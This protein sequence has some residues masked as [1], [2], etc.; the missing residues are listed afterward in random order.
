MFFRDRK[1]TFDLILT[2]K[3]KVFQNPF[4]TETGLSDFHKLILTFFQTLITLLKPKIVFYRNYKHFQESRFLE[5][6]NS[7]NFI[8]NH[9][10]NYNRNCTVNGVILKLP[11]V[12]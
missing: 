7:T 12:L 9:T 4:V 1:S 2:N 10:V 6:L 5:D 8:F 3:Q 11:A